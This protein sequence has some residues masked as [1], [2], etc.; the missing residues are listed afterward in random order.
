MATSHKPYYQAIR[1]ALDASLNLRFHPS[2]IVERQVHP[3]VEMAEKGSKLLMKPIHI[4]YSEHENCLIEGSVN[5]VR[6]SFLIKKGDPNN[7]D[8]SVEVL[9]SR[10]YQQFLA[11]RAER[12]KIFRKKAMEGY[13]FSFL[14]TEDHLTKYRKEDL[15]NLVV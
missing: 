12:F 6:I 13:D 10:M 1:D 14:I 5:S 9:L 11:L 15:I 4:A 3:E 2:E 8:G 7:P